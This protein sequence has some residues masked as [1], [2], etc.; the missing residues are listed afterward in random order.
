M[1]IYTALQRGEYHENYCEDSLYY[2][3][4]GK[5]KML[6]AVMDGCTTAMESHFSSTLISKIIK[7]ICLEKGYKDFVAYSH[8]KSSLETELKSIMSDLMQEL[9]TIK[10][11]LLLDT[12]ELLT[13]LLL[14][15]VD[16][17]TNEGILLAIGDGFVN[18]NG[19]ITDLE[20]DNKP[21]Y[22][23]FHCND[24]FESFYTSQ[25]H[26]IRINTISD[27]TIATDGIF[28]FESFSK[29]KT[30]EDLNCIDYL[31]K[32]KAQEESNE[33]LTFKLKFIENQ[34]GKKPTDD[35]AMIRIIK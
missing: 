1:K 21:D 4:Y 35:F 27:I 7:K 18:I 9:K 23:G 16:Q 30:D 26:I 19:T 25:K 15:L 17:T 31:T 32:N 34:L 14:L 20:Q 24:D 22:L 12:K 10:N 8:K 2:G 28:T 33:M 6:F 13:T 3:K 5:D 11:Q 29:N